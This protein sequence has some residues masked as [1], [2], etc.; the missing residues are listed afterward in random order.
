MDVHRFVVKPKHA[1]LKIW[2]QSQNFRLQQGDMKQ[3]PYSGVTNIRRHRN[4]VVWAT[5][6][7]I[8][9]ANA[10]RK[11]KWQDFESGHCCVFPRHFSRYY[12]WFNLTT[13]N[14]YS[15]KSVIE[16]LRTQSFQM[17]AL[18]LNPGLQICHHKSAVLRMKLQASLQGVLGKKR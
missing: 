18:P 12:L 5:W 3:V 15:W 13:N 8:I 2:E 16:K 14:V 6:S 1:S 11:I 9:F 17:S 7:A 4:V 10:L